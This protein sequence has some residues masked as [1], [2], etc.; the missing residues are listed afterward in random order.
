MWGT[1]PFR[2]LGPGSARIGKSTETYGNP[3]T[4]PTI[5]QS[6]LVFKMAQIFAALAHNQQTLIWSFAWCMISYF[7]IM[8]CILFSTFLSVDLVNEKKVVGTDWSPFHPLSV[9]LLMTDHT[10]HYVITPLSEY[11][12]KITKFSK[13]FYFIT[14]NMITITHLIVG[15][16]AAKFVFSDSLHSRR[17]GVILYEFRSFLDAFDGTVYRSRAANKLY[18]SDH[19]NLGF[20]VDSFCDTLSGFFLCF[21]VLFA[22]YWKIPPQQE[23]AVLPWT[24]DDDVKH[25]KNGGFSIETHTTRSTGGY[26]KM[27]IFW[28]TLCFGMILGLSSSMWD[29]T[30]LKYNEVFMTKFEQVEQT[31]L[32]SQELHSASTWTII[33]LWRVLEGQ[34]LLQMIC[35]AIFID[36]IWEFLTFIQYLGFVVVGLLVIVSNYH[37]YHIKQMLQL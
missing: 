33:W 30:L 28:R 20:W 36:K 17:I 26:S 12:D 9:K 1:V 7:F 27:F 10:T 5:L 35:V 34:A 15:F 21:A 14:P 25:Q 11:F 3:R 23:A 29:Q 18:V 19:N 22:L 13:I 4:F 2:R 16:V 24:S 6:Q 8:D 32:Q 37:A 31:A